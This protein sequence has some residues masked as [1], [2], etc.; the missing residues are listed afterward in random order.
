M[1]QKDSNMEERKPEY[2]GRTQ[3]QQDSNEEMGAMSVILF[4]GLIILGAIWNFVIW[5]VS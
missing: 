5:L 2:Q 3:K 1:Y 4:L